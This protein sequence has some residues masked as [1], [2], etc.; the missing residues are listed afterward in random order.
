MEEEMVDLAAKEKERKR[1]ILQGENGTK[2][3]KCRKSLT[4]TLCRKSPLQSP[5]FCQLYLHIKSLKSLPLSL[6]ES[7]HR[8]LFNSP[9]NSIEIPFKLP[10]AVFQSNFTTYT[11]QAA[12]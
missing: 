6:L 9:N 5:L 4:K 8:F 12:K 7:L 3:P 10:L 11:A 2:I 1:R